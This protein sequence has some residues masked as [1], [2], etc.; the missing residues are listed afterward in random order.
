MGRTA[1]VVR[2]GRVISVGVGSG[3]HAALSKCENK[4]SRNAP[5]YC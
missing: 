3:T 5:L 1:E 4:N 2:G